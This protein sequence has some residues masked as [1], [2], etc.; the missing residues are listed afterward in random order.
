MLAMENVLV[1]S[2]DISCIKTRASINSRLFFKVIIAFVIV[3]C[4]R[5]KQIVRK[6]D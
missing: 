5:K 4:A 2:L 3:A 6:S 1:L